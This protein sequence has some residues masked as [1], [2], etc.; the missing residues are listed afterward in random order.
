M[1]NAEMKNACA[2]A[3]QNC[4]AAL[5][6]LVAAGVLE[7]VAAE[8][9]LAADAAQAKAS[10]GRRD[11]PVGA[12]GVTVL[13]GRRNGYR[14]V[15]WPG[16]VHTIE[17]RAGP[18]EW[19]DVGGHYRTKD[20]ALAFIDG[21][22][23]SRLS[24]PR[25]S[26]TAI[27]IPDGGPKVGRLL[28]HDDVR[29]IMREELTHS[30]L[31]LVDDRDR[32][33]GGNCDQMM[34]SLV[35]QGVD[36]SRLTISDAVDGGLDPHE[37]GV[38]DLVSDSVVNQ[39]RHD[40]SPSVDGCGDH[41]GVDSPWTPEV[42]RNIGYDV[43]D[44]LLDGL[45]STLI[46][47]ASLSRNSVISGQILDDWRAAFDRVRSESGGHDVEAL[48]AVTLG[49]L[50]RRRGRRRVTDL[51]DRKRNA[52]ANENGDGAGGRCDVDAE[53]IPVPG[54]RVADRRDD[55]IQRPRVPAEGVAAAAVVDDIAHEASPCSV[56]VGT[57]SVGDGQV[58]GGEPSPPATEAN[59]RGPIVSI[60][61]GPAF[62]LDD[63]AKAMARE[64]RDAMPTFSVL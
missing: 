22:L 35:K 40:S 53:P 39:S 31:A 14:L 10:V 60:E 28:T 54:V 34:G 64:I 18:G 30:I 47:S 1:T 44:H 6:R 56:G 33:P 57:P 2:A 13:G 12:V 17:H 55:A 8:E 51:L 20:A 3:Q 21:R 45:L 49:L 7:K 41:E 24:S 32:N 25:K 63:F 48:S 5:D 23:S 15:Q 61:N 36:S 27:P 26:G 9:I 42:V 46:R 37:F 16:P 62:D 52:G 58:A 11:V 4:E 43:A 50:E 29:A 19:S 38:R 59:R